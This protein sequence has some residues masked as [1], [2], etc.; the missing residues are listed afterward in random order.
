MLWVCAGS[1]LLACGCAGDQKGAESPVGEV[2]QAPE[3]TTTP[4]AGNENTT[5]P[6][7]QPAG[8]PQAE[9]PT[10][11]LNS[12][13]PSNALG[14]ST[15]TPEAPV[16]ATLTEAQ[17][18]RVAD[19]VNTAEIEQGKLAQT[20][21]RSPKVKA[22]AAK[23][24]SHHQMAKNEQA[25]LAKR[26]DLSPAES[27]DAAALQ[28]DGKSTMKSL[29]EA[30]SADFDALYLDGQVTSHQKVLATLDEQLL[31]SAKSPD[32]TRALRAAREAV[33]SHLEEAKTLRAELSGR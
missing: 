25:R 5:P 1:F 4:P 28:T 2:E 20:K 8:L 27:A 7:G 12:V 23:M 26:L 22:F 24:V 30:K 17:I 19:L 31:P 15:A 3:M 32:V 10:Q 16:R 29:K 14:T 18:A 21:A 9:P 33:A 6:T 13:T 11:G